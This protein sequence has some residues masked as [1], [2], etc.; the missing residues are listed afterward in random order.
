VNN[1]DIKYMRRALQLARNGAGEV[2]P[3]P[4]VG[5]V[6]VAHDRVIGEGWHRRFGQPHAE[7]NAINS[8]AECDVA[9]L[10]ESTV[11][12]TLEPCSH[13][14]KTPPCADLLISKGVQRVV[15]GCLDPFEKVSG[16]GVSKLRDAGI[17][18][19]EGVLKEECELLNR[20]FMTAHRSHRP[21]VQ[22]KWAQSCDGFIAKCS[23]TGGYEPVKLSTP[24]SLVWMHRERSLADAIMVGTNTVICDNPRLDVRYWAGHNPIKISFNRTD[25]LPKSS[26]LAQDSDSIIINDNRSLDNLIEGLYHDHGITSVMV[27]GGSKLLESFITQGLWNEL[28]I[29]ISP[30]LLHR[31]IKAPHL[32]EL[33]GLKIYEETV[34]NNIIRVIRR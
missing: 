19:T 24:I 22:L 28:R 12:V 33:E 23:E 1:D 15:V 29:E 20:R 8:I 4:M 10:K 26:K 11:Y 30:L 17:E 6:V 18:V 27:E 25:R 9:L 13:Y 3:N 21:Y 34:E 32:P 2:S 16:R 14:G 5:A 31:G 7:V